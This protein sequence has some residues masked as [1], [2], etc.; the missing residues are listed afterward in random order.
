MKSKA[1]P[2][3]FLLI[4]LSF[5]LSLDHLY[6]LDENIQG[7]LDVTGTSTLR[8]DAYFEGTTFFGKLPVSNT[9]GFRVTVDQE[10][11]NTEIEEVTPGHFESATVTVLDFG[12]V[13]HPVSTW[14][15]DFGYVWRE[16]W[17]EE[18]GYYYPQVWFPDVYSADEQLITPGYWAQGYD[19]VWGIVGGHLEGNSEWGVVGGHLETSGGEWGPVGS[20]QEVQD[21]WVDTVRSSY[22]STTYGIPQTK[23]IGQASEMVWSFNNEDRKLAE[24]STAGLS[25]PYP[26][27]VAGSSRAMLT[28]TQ[29]EQSY[30]T[31]AG[32]LGNYVSYGAKLAKDGVH[33]WEDYGEDQVVNESASSRLK[34]SELLIQRKVPSSNGVTVSTVGTRIGATDA[35]F[36]GLVKVSGPLLVNPQ[37]DLTMG[38]F[39]NGPKP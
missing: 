25:I 39:T 13:T 12:Y 9:P 37:G 8:Q 30:T 5:S 17:V 22:T 6:A 20:H 28:A 3:Y 21:V 32:E 11:T 35:Q 36:G 16:T 4:A 27:D 19:P 18:W 23:F 24:F 15:E 38:S 26:G 14:V 34:P 1:N 7:N 31:A 33:M 29:F 10:V 2:P